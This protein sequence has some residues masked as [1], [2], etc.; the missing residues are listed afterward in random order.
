MLL[1]LLKFAWTSSLSP[2]EMSILICCGGEISM[3]TSSWSTRPSAFWPLFHLPRGGVCNLERVATIDA[4]YICNEPMATTD[5]TDAA[6][7]GF[8]RNHAFMYNHTFSTRRWSI[9]LNL[10]NV[11]FYTPTASSIQPSIF[12]KRMFPPET[13]GWSS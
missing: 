7:N 12:N 6:A 4:A 13:P 1:C 2:M 9:I 5:Y 11:F 3:W 10:S 8:V